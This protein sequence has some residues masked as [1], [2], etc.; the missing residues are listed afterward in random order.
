MQPSHNNPKLKNIK[1]TYKN[2]FYYFYMLH[3]FT[4]MCVFFKNDTL[5]KWFEAVYTTVGK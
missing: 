3:A 1:I 2:M 5:S 4:K